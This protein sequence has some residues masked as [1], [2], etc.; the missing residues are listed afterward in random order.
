MRLATLDTCVTNHLQGGKSEEGRSGVGIVHA[1]D[2][3]VE[4]CGIVYRV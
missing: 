4:P 3:G 2:E 1:D